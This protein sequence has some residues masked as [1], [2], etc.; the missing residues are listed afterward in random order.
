MINDFM[1]KSPDFEI[2]FGGKTDVFIAKMD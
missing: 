1:P 2:D